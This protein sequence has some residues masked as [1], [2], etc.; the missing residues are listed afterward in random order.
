ML[1]TVVFAVLGAGATARN[2]PRNQGRGVRAVP[3]VPTCMVLGIAT[4][5]VPPSSLE[6]ASMV[7]TIPNAPGS[8]VRHG[9]A[10]TVA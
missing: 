7:L 10:P 2:R 5:A 3:I 1:I 8:P 4:I 6:G 9:H